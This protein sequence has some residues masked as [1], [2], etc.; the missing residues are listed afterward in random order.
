[1]P[2]DEFSLQ[3][4]YNF[5]SKSLIIDEVGEI[6]TLLVDALLNHGCQVTYWGSEKKETFAY[7]LGK[8]NFNYFV[9]LE[10]LSSLEKIDYL[11]YF[12]GENFSSWEKVSSLAKEKQ[13]RV[14]ICHPQGLSENLPE[15]GI[16]RGK[17]IN[18]RVV[19]FDCLFGP[20]VKQGIL[21]SLFAK[22]GFG[23]QIAISETSQKE[24][25]PLSSGRL[26]EELLRLIFS[27]DTQGKIYFLEAERTSLLSFVNLLQK[28]FPQSS[29]RF[30]EEPKTKNPETKEVKKIPITENLEEKIEEAVSWFRRN[31]PVSPVEEVKV[32]PKEEKLEKMEKKEGDL[33]FLFVGK[34]ASP[35]EKK[36][37]KKPPFLKKIFF[38][39]GVFF[40]LVFIFFGLPVVLLIFSTYLGFKSLVAV[41]EEM[42]KANFPLA[43]KN[44]NDS[45]KMFEIA[46]KTIY[47]TNPFYSL[48]SLG[49]SLEAL[50]ES[51]AVAQ[52][53]NRS[54]RFSLQAAEDAASLF[55]FF[56][57]GEEAKW[58]DSLG[59]I[60]ANLS[61]AYQ[62]ASLAQS[63]LIKAEP[64]F[65]LLKQEQIHD[66]WESL[67]P[68][69]RE[70]LLKSQ[71]AIGLL[72]KILGL[73]ER[74]TYLVLF[75]NNLELR[76]TGGFISSYG[77]VNLENGKLVNFEVFD[78][79]QADNLLKGRVDPPAKI[80][81]Y[82]GET[83]WYLR[84]SN[85]DPD[86][87]SSAKKAQWFLDK[88][89]QITTEGV[90]AVNL[91]VFEDLLGVL[92]E[93]EMADFP[94]KIN[95]GNFLA[96][97][98]SFLEPVGVAK[99]TKSK[100]FFALVVQAI[101]EK[102]K[103]ANKENLVDLSKVLLTMLDQKEIMAY[104][105]DQEIA[106]PLAFLGWEGGIKNFSP[107]SNMSTV[108]AD[109]LLINEA[110]VGINKAN[111][112][113]ERKIDH[114][115]TLN[116]Q[117]KVEEKLM[118]IYENK[119][120]SESWSAGNYK[121]Y[122]RLYLPKGSQATSILTSDSQNNDLWVPFNTKL[123][124]I[125]EEHDK[126]VLGLFLEVASRSRK[127]LEITYEPFKR[128]EFSQKLISYL[129]MIQKQSG[130]Y[131]VGYD[132][133]FYYPEKFVPLR[134]IPKA[135]VGEQQLLLS[136]KL[137]RDRVF[138]ID[139]GH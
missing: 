126:A 26:I 11:F 31:F 65:K 99:D 51:F 34:I 87:P 134:V 23:G 88:E 67:L 95:Q 8:D 89:V 20:R 50:N 96:K 104:F 68:V 98:Q 130:A 125:Y 54:L 129:L 24:I 16:L 2:K 62:E 101:Y 109:Y 69:M 103:K 42:K 131:S 85:W 27:G 10:E 28:F 22:A 124:D 116:D 61:L 32:L 113:M 12:P 9:S 78:I 117:G 66:Q 120:P 64:G 43:I 119:S 4:E 6:S 106:R 52:N 13:A 5:Y 74:K 137:D 21:G 41:Q 19:L 102:I 45:E 30:S 36:E 15:K 82:L 75:Q 38:G 72:P 35:E 105:D 81:E 29:F 49:S 17:E 58:L 44:I 18:I 76:P 14:L 127:R 121:C 3:T 55:H 59:G 57:N 63:S 135:I 37:K 136:E 84:D 33:D 97:A 122:L 25:S 71:N 73:G 107:Q 48:V 56:V 128:T 92:G 138:Q 60:R 83:T 70:T 115:I 94:E 86:F 80:K 114:K 47:L 7:L 1:M 133:T 91:G 139:F 112:F 123:L 110:N 77:V 118:I 132:L 111:Y 90:I 46:Q 39:G 40:F 100:N 53:L 93:I 108:L 79:Y